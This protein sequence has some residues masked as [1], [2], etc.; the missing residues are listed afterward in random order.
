MA[1]RAAAGAIRGVE[2]DMPNSNDFSDP[3]LAS[4]LLPGLGALRKLARHS[5]A[6]VGSIDAHCVIVSQPRE[7]VQS[8]LAPGL[9]LREPARVTTHDVVLV[10]AHHR[11]VRPGIVPFGGLAYTEV[12]EIIPDV[13]VPGHNFQRDTLFSY[14]PNLLLDNPVPVAVGQNVYGFSK[15][16][17]R[18]RSTDDS[19][20]VR[21]AF[22]AT[23]ARFT[24]TGL[25]GDISQFKEIVD[26]QRKL[27]LP[28]I[29]VAQDGS[30]VFSIIDFQLEHGT[31]QRITGA[32]RTG[33]PFF[34]RPENLTVEADP[35][36][37]PWGFHMECAWSL[38]LPVGDIGRKARAGGHNLRMLTAGYG[39]AMLGKIPFRR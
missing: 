1:G 27:E 37:R 11:D 36:K 17:A 20:D 13:E 3:G 6:G 18:I 10:F 29:G 5:A 34:A 21:S 39:E 19:F 25:P 26:I 14:M 8:R 12:F 30:L 23:A 24:R 28:L 16:L 32:I 9:R 22:G 2:I 38:S 7:D 33:A 35:T 31:F 15:Q 4:I